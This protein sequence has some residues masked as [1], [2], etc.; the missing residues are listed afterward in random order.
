MTLET[1]SAKESRL[2]GFLWKTKHKRTQ[3][4][5]QLEC[6]PTRLPAELLKTNSHHRCPCVLLPEQRAPSSLAV[7]RYT[8]R[9]KI[10]QKWLLFSAHPH[11]NYLRGGWLTLTRT[12]AQQAWGRAQAW[13]HR[14]LEWIGLK[15]IL[16]ITLFQSPFHR[17]GQLPLDQAALY[18]IQP[19]LEQFQGWG[20]H[21]F[22]EQPV[23]SSSLNHCP[24]SEAFIP[25]I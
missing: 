21:S 18:P 12:T 7:G 6:F 22:S 15:G 2:I 11:E 23:S 5:K 9:K 13:N 24:H 20:I 25:N 3:A 10:L 4:D 16:K 14:I 19:G 17:Q 1:L 8:E